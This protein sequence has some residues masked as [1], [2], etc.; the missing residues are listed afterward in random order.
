MAEQSIIAGFGAGVKKWASEETAK[1]IANTIGE[2]NKLSESQNKEISKLVKET[3]KSA[4]DGKIDPKVAKELVDSMEELSDEVEENTEAKRQNTRQS[5]LFSDSLGFAASATKDLAVFMGGTLISALGTVT[6]SILKQADM[7]VKLNQAG[8]N[9]T[10]TTGDIESGI[11]T[12]GDAA[13]TARLSFSELKGLT[14][15]YSATM[16]RYGIQSFARMSN[17][18]TRDLSHL[19]LVADES[20][21]LVAEYLK[22]QRFIAYTESMTQQQREQAAMN[23][24]SEL[25]EYSKVLGESRTEIAKAVSQSLEQVNVQGY[26]ASLEGENAEA[27]RGVFRSVSARLGSEELSGLRDQLTQIMASQ[28]PQRSELYGDLIKAAPDAADA[29]LDLNQAAQAGDQAGVNRALEAFGSGIDGANVQLAQLIDEQNSAAIAAINQYKRLQQL[30]RESGGVDPEADNIAQAMAR[31]QNSFRD[32]TNF[33]DYASSELFN[34]AGFIELFTDT[35]KEVSDIL[36]ENV[37]NLRTAFSNILKGVVPFVKQVIPV[38]ETFGEWVKGW[39]EDLADDTEGFDLA[40]SLSSI[41]SKIGTAL[42]GVFGGTAIAAIIGGALATGIAGLLSR[43]AFGRGGSGGIFGNIFKGVGKGVGGALSALAAGLAAFGK[44]GPAVLKGAGILSAAIVIIGAGIAGATWIMGAALPKFA[45]GLKGFEELDGQN[46]ANVG[47]GVMKLGAGLAA[48][49]AGRIGDLFAGV[50]EAIFEFFGGESNGPIEM[51]RQFSDIASEVGPGISQLGNA[52]QSFVPNLSEMISSIA[53]AENI[54]V[55]NLEETLNSLT[56]ID[57]ID[58]PEVLVTAN[59][60]NTSEI[61]RQI[62]DAVQ[63]ISP[64]RQT[65]TNVT[66]TSIDA[67]S[68]A[69]EQAEFLQGKVTRLWETLARLEESGASERVQARVQQQINSYNRMLSGITRVNGQRLDSEPVT[70]EMALLNESAE[71]VATADFSGATEASQELQQATTSMVSSLSPRDIERLESRR[72][73]IERFIARAESMGRGNLGSMDIARDRLAQL[74]QIL[75]E[76]GENQQDS[77][78]D[79]SGVLANAGLSELPSAIDNERSSLET[80][81]NNYFR[82]LQRLE[83]VKPISQSARVEFSPLVDRPQTDGTTEQPQD[84]PTTATAQRQYQRVDYTRPPMQV[85]Q[86][87][88]Q[89]NE[90]EQVAV[91]ENTENEQRTVEQRTP[92]QEPEINTLIKEQNKILSGLTIA[93]DTNNKRLKNLVRINEEKGT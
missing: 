72:D 75:S 57:N 54:D 44:A 22:N 55:N 81:I 17:R 92:E 18:V 88:P 84:T 2:L 37:P 29:L 40:E 61:E 77:P 24:V 60:V 78:I 5:N 85:A 7:A 47:E 23:F 36:E 13:R 82:E 30:E 42:L 83:D 45:E 19:G 35:F 9:L 12:F 89:Q 46:L 27:I 16:N 65:T 4:K 58:I 6:G 10:S 33:F 63:T 69:A 11:A 67:D 52:L 74:N 28:V 66:E 53:A 49:A 91:N 32:V 39:T 86:P 48:M 93:M 38:L 64:Q 15:E 31:M 51:L 56:E 1:E 87:E 80:A 21:E 43:V 62:N 70:R 8:I 73:A 50:G 71:A 41:P 20:A 3:A 76:A 79:F 68:S 25:S 34:D 90:I 59:R 14:E 26:L